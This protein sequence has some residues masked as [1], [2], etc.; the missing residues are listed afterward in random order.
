MKKY[1]IKTLQ[2]IIEVIS[3][4]NLDNFLIDFKRWLEIQIN[5]KNINKFSIRI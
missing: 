5:I 1:Q 2:E 3:A 4:D